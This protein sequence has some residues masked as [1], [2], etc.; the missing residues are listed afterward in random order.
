MKVL[1]VG[2]KERLQQK[3]S[4]APRFPADSVA[5]TVPSLPSERGGWEGASVRFYEGRS[6]GDHWTVSA[7]YSSASVLRRCVARVSLLRLGL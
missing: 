4:A 1:F 7:V 6:A 2:F 5:C 3:G